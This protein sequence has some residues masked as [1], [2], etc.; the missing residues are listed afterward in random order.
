[1]ILTTRMLIIP[2][3]KY[4]KVP[5]MIVPILILKKASS[6]FFSINLKLLIKFNRMRLLHVEGFEESVH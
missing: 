3:I 1:V 5:A 6:C 2:Q 4:Y